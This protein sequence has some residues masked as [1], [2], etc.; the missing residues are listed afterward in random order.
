[1]KD[2]YIASGIITTVSLVEAFALFFIRSGG[3]MNISIA[4]A[5]YAVGAVPLLALAVKYEGIG[6]TNFLWNVLST[7]I[8]FAIGVLIFKEKV[9]NMQIMGVIVS[10]VGVAMILLDPGVK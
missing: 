2:I 9:R 1:M 4:S 7:I 8:G 10:L 6:L 5:I 3:F